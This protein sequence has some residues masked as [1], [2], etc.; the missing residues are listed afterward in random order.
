[1]YLRFRI[2]GNENLRY[3]LGYAAAAV[4]IV[5]AAAIVIAVRSPLRE[6]YL[7]KSTFGIFKVDIIQRSI[8]DFE[9]LVIAVVCIGGN[10]DLYR[11]FGLPLLCTVTR[12]FVGLIRICTSIINNG[13]PVN[14]SRRIYKDMH[15][16]LL[17]FAFF[18]AF[19]FAI[20]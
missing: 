1:M 9:I 12:L 2:S 3:V 14:V 19:P 18:C 10:V 4:C 7:V 15:S 8:L 6:C 11:L 5:R 16:L 17:A 20:E 13:A